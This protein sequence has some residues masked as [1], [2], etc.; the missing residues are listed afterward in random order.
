MGWSLQAEWKSCRCGVDLRGGAHNPK[1]CQAPFVR[2][3]KFE[4][5]EAGIAGQDIRWGRQEAVGSPS[6][7]LVPERGELPEHVDGGPED[8]RAIAEDGEEE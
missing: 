8:V 6:L 2:E 1:V 7:H 3:E 4:W 5:W